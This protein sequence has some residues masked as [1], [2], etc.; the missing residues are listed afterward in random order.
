MKR[1]DV[2]AAAVINIAR[3]AANRHVTPS[4]DF[5]HL[6]K[7]VYGGTTF[8]AIAYPRCHTIYGSASIL[9][10]NVVADYEIGRKNRARARARTRSRVLRFVRKNERI[11]Y[12]IRDP[13]QYY[14]LRL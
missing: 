8:D 5:E 9:W 6:V 11:F 10:T 12:C 3:L 7:T 13:G 14:V 1:T 2:R 4:M